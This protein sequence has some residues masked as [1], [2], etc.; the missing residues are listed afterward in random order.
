MG[1]F[2]TVGMPFW[3][4]TLGENQS[5]S[6]PPTHPPPGE[7]S[8]GRMSLMIVESLLHQH[9]KGKHMETCKTLP[10]VPHASNE[11]L[12]KP[13]ESTLSEIA[14]GFGF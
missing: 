8:G 10:S 13:V 12:Q 3:S 2:E 1:P 4:F 5:P 14:I 9:V 7:K 11:T 6:R